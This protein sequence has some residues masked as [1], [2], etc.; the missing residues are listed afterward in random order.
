MKIFCGAVKLK[1]LSIC[2]EC[3]KDNKKVVTGEH[4]LCC[5]SIRL[6]VC[7]LIFASHDY[8][9]IKNIHSPLVNH[10]V[11]APELYRSLASAPWFILIVKTYIDNVIPLYDHI[12][13]HKT[14]EHSLFFL[15]SFIVCL[16][17]SWLFFLVYSTCVHAVFWSYLFLLL[18]F[19]EVAEIWHSIG[20]PLVVACNK[21]WGIDLK[22][23]IKVGRIR[24]TVTLK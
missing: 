11:V 16:F 22:G 20:I 2:S 5:M 10:L 14:S 17:L 4:T 8:V 7:H 6:C 1:K 19:C 21:S 24:S 9:I 15:S 3:I 18:S 13:N 23:M 12:Q